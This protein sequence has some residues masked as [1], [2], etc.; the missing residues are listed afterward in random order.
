MQI[1]VRGILKNIAVVNPGQ[2]SR[3]E[4]MGYDLYDNLPDFREVVQIADD[5]LNLPTKGSL[6]PRRQLSSVV[7]SVAGHHA[8][9]RSL[10]G[11]A[12][13]YATGLSIGENSALVQQEVAGF[14]PV[15]RALDIRQQETERPHP[16]GVVKTMFAVQGISP[17]VVQGRV[18]IEEGKGN[19]IMSAVV[20]N[21][22]SPIDSVLSVRINGTVRDALRLIKERLHDLEGVRVIPLPVLNAFHSDELRPEQESFR[23]KIGR[24]LGELTL[25]E[26]LPDREIYSPMISEWVKTKTDAAKMFFNQLTSD[27]DFRKVWPEFLARGVEGVV[28]F[29]YKKYLPEL[30]DNN[31]G[32]RILV[33]NISDYPSFVETGNQV[34]ASGRQ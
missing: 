16:E 27:L 8:L 31:T 29:D 22:N 5:A 26:T 19:S 25:R 24:I 6:D 28:S 1:E 11:L 3:G 18:E 10:G 4:K 13:R 20:S 30:I 21:F 17:E 14:E 15:I 12:F 2:N 33:L 7:F 34:T 9:V 23:E 32:R